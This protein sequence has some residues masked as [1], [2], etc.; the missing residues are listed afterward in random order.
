MR[1]NLRISVILVSAIFTADF[2]S[3]AVADEIPPR[4]PGGWEVVIE[5]EKI[6]KVTMKMCID[7]ETDRL[8]HKIGTDLAEQKCTRKDVKVVDNV[9]TIDSECKIS[10]SKVT[11]TTVM[12][13][14]ED[15]AFHS[16]AK[17]HFEP[18]LLGKTDAVTTQDGKW[19]GPCPSG[20]K[21]GDFIVADGI[22]VNIKTLDMLRKFLPAN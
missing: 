1:N 19:T 6:P 9:A 21:P 22:K 8:F 2:L 10:N 11:G 4:K 15:T 13:F 18:A 5:G 20:M 16:E 3:A 12:K 17:A 7:K 14:T